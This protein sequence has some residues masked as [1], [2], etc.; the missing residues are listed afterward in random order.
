MSAAAQ[1]VQAPA[2]AALH[3]RALPLVQVLR[4]VAALSVAF[5][6]ITQQ[7]GVFV[8]R[9]GEPA[10]GWLRPLPWDAGVDVFFV[11]SGFVM[12]WSS[13]RLFGRR[14]AARLFLGR[15]I[16]RI[17][18][19]YW[20]MTS[21]LVA[22]AL[23]SPHAISDGL[24]SIRYVVA[25]YLFIPVQRPDGFIQPVF[26]LGWTLNYEML[27]YAIFALFIRLQARVA[28]P[29]VV[30]TIVVLAGIGRV[31]RPASPALAFWT[32]S[33]VLE[34]AFGV[35]LATLALSGARLTPA[36]RLLLV[37]AALALL[38]VS[39]RL[40][41]LPI[42]SRWTEFWVLLGDASYALYL[43]HPFPMRAFEIVWLRLGWTGPAA[44]LAYIASAVVATIV[45]AFA[46]HRW[47]ERPATAAT[48]RLLHA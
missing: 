46:L 45:A 30:A 11:I 14:D 41:E 47:L 15:R 40:P 1:V 43:V 3:P 2:A 6:H 34:F 8:G 35:L 7:A 32:D 5:L 36:P 10:Y 28:V 24:E 18:P 23:V 20:A 39:D 21:L 16:A 42:R 38:V 33:I 4:A 17:V 19:L 44:V 25:S 22:V 37:F 29:W 9:P 27:F 12:V 13:M 48:R 26:R 31:L